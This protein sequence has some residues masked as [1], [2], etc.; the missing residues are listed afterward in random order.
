MVQYRHFA[1]LAEANRIDVQPEGA[2]SR[3]HYR[4]QWAGAGVQLFGLYART[5]PQKI[6]DVDAAIDEVGKIVEISARDRRRFKRLYEEFPPTTVC[7]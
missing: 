6:A 2:E 5:Q 4:P 1:T 7:R 3:H